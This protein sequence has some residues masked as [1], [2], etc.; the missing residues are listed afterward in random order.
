MVDIDSD[1]DL[2]LVSSGSTGGFDPQPM[3]VVNDNLE[4]Q[5][6]PNF[7]PAVP[8][9]NEAL[10]RGNSVTLSWLVDCDR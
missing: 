10:A 8:S 3:T 2:D 1:G 9:T 5:F 4:A 6:N 7:S